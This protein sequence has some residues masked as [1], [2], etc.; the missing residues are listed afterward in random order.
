M[1][2]EEKIRE[3]LYNV[4]TI[5]DLFPDRSKIIRPEEISL[6]IKK[7][8][9][10]EGMCIYYEERALYY[11]Y[12]QIKNALKNDYQKLN[13]FYGYV[14]GVEIDTLDLR[15]FESDNLYLPSV[16]FNN[17]HFHKVIL[18][19]NYDR[20]FSRDYLFEGGIT[21]DEV[22][23]D[24]LNSESFLNHHRE[25]RADESPVT[26]KN[27]LYVE[28]SRVC[29]G[30]CTFCRNH[31]LPPCKY[32]LKNIITNLGIISPYVKYVIFGGGEPT[33]KIDDLYAIMNSGVIDN[34]ENIIF[35]NGTGDYDSYRLRR[36]FRSMFS[37]NLSRHHYDDKE[38][39]RILGIDESKVMNSQQLSSFIEYSHVTLAATLHQDGLNNFQDIVGYLQYCTDMGAENILLQTLHEDLDETN[40]YDIDKELDKVIEY[41]KLCGYKASLPI[42]SSSNYCMIILSSDIN[43]N[44]ISIKRYIKEQDNKFV[45]SVKKSFDLAMDPSGRVY[46]S[47]NEKNKKLDLKK[48]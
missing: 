31:H 4:T 47:W 13:F 26:F 37:Y 18:P 42:Y 34:T 1:E 2:N 23:I 21:I 28:L 14:D 20:L 10:F 41:L 15:Y 9:C 16:I 6:I 19:E 11:L 25:F 27:S 43:N 35:T 46:S 12:N 29:N 17:V 48:L 33:L 36:K 45:S 32:D 38:N 8:E 39:A 22:I 7:I 24:N 44:V 30:K 3:E 5:N 40:N